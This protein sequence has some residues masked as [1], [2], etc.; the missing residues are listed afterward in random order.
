MLR[1]SGVRRAV[2]T[3]ESG[4]IGEEVYEDR[5][6]CMDAEHWAWLGMTPPEVV[7]EEE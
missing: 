2:W 5:E 1:A 4:Q 6:A 3:T 7:A